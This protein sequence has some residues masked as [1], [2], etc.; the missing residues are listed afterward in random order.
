MAD[1]PLTVEQEMWLGRLARDG[2]SQARETLIAANSWIVEKV[3]S[4]YAGRYP[5]APFVDLIQEGFVGLLEAVSRYDPRRRV[6]LSTYAT[7]WIRMRIRRAARSAAGMPPIPLRSLSQAEIREGR[8]PYVPGPDDCSDLVVGGREPRP[9]EALER[10]DDLD[11]VMRALGALN[12]RHRDVVTAFYGIDRPRETS[13]EIGARIGASQNRVSQM[14]RQV[15]TRIRRK[16]G[17]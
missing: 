11:F 17:R 7:Y 1:H 13:A 16:A 5:D 9:D 14:V 4:G 12:E 10:A 3:A 6:R 15:I 2:D 8:R